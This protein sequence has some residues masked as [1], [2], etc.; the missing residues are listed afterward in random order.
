MTPFRPP[1]IDNVCE[2]A[3]RLPCS[4]SLLPRLTSVLTASDSSAEEIADLI[5]LDSALAA[6]TLRLANSAV[7]SANG[8]DVETV[9]D[10][11][12]RLGQ[13]ELYRLAAYALVGRWEAGAGA[14]G[15]PGAFCRHALCTAIA[16]EVLAETSERIDPQTA[17]TAGLVCDLGKLAVA[18]ACAPFFPAIRTHCAT[19]GGT[20][21]DA[22]REV[23]GY[24][25]ADVGARLLGAWSFPELFIEA[26]RHMET[27][28]AAPEDVQILLAHLHAAKYV[29]MSFG[30][31]SIDEGFI[32]DL[33]APFIVDC[34]FT[35]ELLQETMSIVHERA[36]SR[37]QS[38]PAGVR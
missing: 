3:L 23:L 20:W 21:T 29:A 32:L 35:A 5:R 9:S 25:H 28:P 18:H 16:A 17:Y 7:F 12:I 27:P 31:G 26:A 24:T 30:S 2:R 14:G 1:T 37:L 33:E 36:K 34:G 8:G 10:A 38:K 13:L 6:A 11:V 19:R 4:P 15:E 22:Q